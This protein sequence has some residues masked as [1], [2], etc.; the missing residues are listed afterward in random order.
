MKFK[1]LFYMLLLC[2]LMML[3]GD[4]RFLLNEAIAGDKD[5][6]IVIDGKKGDWN[7]LPVLTKALNNE[8]DYF[9]EEVGAAVT[10]RVDVRYVKAFIDAEKD[11]LYFYIRFWGGPVWP[12][13]VYQGI[14]E[15]QPVA[16]H[17]GYYHLMLDLDN[18]PSTGWDNRYYEAHLTPLGYYAGQGLS[19]T[20]H[21]GVECLIDLEID[22]YWTPPAQSGEVKYVS[23]NGADTRA[24]DG[25]T[26]TGPVY[27][28]FYFDVEDPQFDDMGYFVGY[29]LGDDG[30]QHWAGHAFGYKFLEYGVSLDAFRAYWT[31]EGLD[32]L[33]P[34]DVIGISAFIETPID[35][36]GVDVSPRGLLHVPCIYLSKN[37][38]A[39]DFSDNGKPASTTTDFRLNPNYPNPF[40][41][42]T[43]IYYSIAEA[44]HVKLMV[45]NIAGEL[46]STLVDGQVDPG[47]HSVKW[48]GRD[49]LGS[50][51]PGGIYFCKIQA[52]EFRQTIRM[53]LLK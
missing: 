12:N 15:G 19:N 27:S 30:E 37:V 52:G 38:N 48:N 51:V 23:Y 44:G 10:D 9:P 13:Y 36:W 47:S 42:Q 14:Y 21:L 25:L 3:I 6:V 26:D 53:T 1:I 43:T 40:N 35:G 22:S 34:G 50:M 33:Q 45:Y 4:G 8:L 11:R 29:T 16:R 49:E 18:D 24:Y 28:M 20:A 46:V 17:R 2:T 7:P 39:D 32:Y 41:P 5:D 31:S